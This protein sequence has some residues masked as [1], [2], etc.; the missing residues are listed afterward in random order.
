MLFKVLVICFLSTLD[1][2]ILRDEVVAPAPSRYDDHCNGIECPKYTVIKTT[3]EYELR[4]YPSFKWAA[5]VQEGLDYSAA[6][7]KNFRK[8]FSYISGANEQNVKIPMTAPVLTHIQVTQGPF[9]AANFTMYFFVPYESQ[10]NTPKPNKDKVFV[11]TMPPMTVYVKS[12]GGYMSVEDIQENSQQ[13]AKD[14]Q[15]AGESFDETQLFSA[16]YDSPFKPIFRHNEVMFFKK[17][18]LLLQTKFGWT[19]VTQMYFL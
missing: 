1:A 12:F 3:D 6:T 10:V 18:K 17:W 9:C 4:Q 5:A 13:L 15:K 14:L 8:L 16:G 2:Y 7:R 19:F 11:V